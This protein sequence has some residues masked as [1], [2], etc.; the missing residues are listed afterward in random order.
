MIIGV[1]KAFLAAYLFHVQIRSL[2]L[3]IRAFLETAVNPKFRHSLFHE[4]LYRYHV[5]DDDS[6]PNPGLTPYY[7][8]NF[9][10]TIKHYKDTSPLN[11]ALLS[12][13]QWYRLLLE[14]RVLMSQA[15]DTS[16]PALLPVRAETLHPS[17]DWPTTWS[18]A[19]TKG[20]GSELTAFL[21]RL[22][23]HLLPTQDRVHRIV[24][25]DQEH[26]ALPGRCSL[27]HAGTEDLMHAFFLCQ[28]S[29]VAGHALLGY[30]QQCLPDLTPEQVLRLELGPD[31]GDGDQ[32]AVVCL[33][34]TGLV[35]IWETRV[36]K[37]AIH[38]YKMRAEVEA[39]ISILR[40][41]RYWASGNKMLDM[42]N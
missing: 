30:A 19:R 29:A 31:L 32:L 11:I 23:H 38:L 10:S 12:T 36:Q 21:F 33:L 1:Y 3:L 9:F 17:T 7:D 34:A 20:L 26:P 6:V 22:L 41:S 39:K 13:K 4:V 37:K 2:A 27:C 5:L 40:K 8:Q 24:G 16:P 28:K 42:M 18:L 14:D 25:A 35:Y 15:T